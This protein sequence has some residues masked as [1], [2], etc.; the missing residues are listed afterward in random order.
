MKTTYLACT[1]FAIVLIG[2]GR[3]S[4]A[5]RAA[6]DEKRS[7]YDIKFSE[8]PGMPFLTNGVSR[9]ELVKKLGEPAWSRSAGA[10][11]WSSFSLNRAT[12]GLP[13]EIRGV[14]VGFVDNKAFSIQPEVMSMVSGVAPSSDSVLRPK[15]AKFTIHAMGNET[16]E[17]QP[18]SVLLNRVD[19][20]AS[21][22][23][24]FS[25][26]LVIPQ[27]DVDKLES[28]TRKHVHED[29]E[30]LFGDSVVTTGRVHEAITTNR[31]DLNFPKGLRIETVY[32]QK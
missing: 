12:K 27:N 13:P 26:T 11:N 23:L 16:M 1:L 21:P 20:E 29:L 22:S 10:T 18:E 32:K 28:F 31:I 14:M 4:P 30:F 5:P 3:T 15:P 25:L 17:V 8:V 2:C 6:D 7:P 9:S 19:T 24:V